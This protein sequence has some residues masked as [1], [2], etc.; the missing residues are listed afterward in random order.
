MTDEGVSDRVVSAILASR[1][2]REVFV[3]DIVD[4]FQF[5]QAATCGAPKAKKGGGV[6]PPPVAGHRS[7][8]R[9]KNVK[10]FPETY[11]FPY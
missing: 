4:H 5:V 6:H 8:Q 9:V 11:C 1:N 2:G 3:T 7:E 10:S